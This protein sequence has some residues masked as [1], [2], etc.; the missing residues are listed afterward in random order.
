MRTCPPLLLCLL[1]LLTP[2][3]V[4]AQQS[5]STP[6]PAPGVQDPKALSVL[7]QCAQVMGTMASTAA[8][9]SSGQLT[10]SLHS[11]ESAGIV[12]EQ[13]G[14]GQMRRTVSWPEGQQVYIVNG[15]QGHATSSSTA[16]PIAP[17]QEQYFRPDYFPSLACTLD[18]TR[19]SMNAVYVDV[20]TLAGS[21]V[22]HI[23]FYAPSQSLPDGSLSLD[24]VISEFDVYLDTQSLMV[25]KTKRFIFAPDAIQNHSDW[26]TY[27]SDY[28]SVSGLMVPFHVQH[29]L[30]GQLLENIVISS[31][32]PN[33]SIPSQDFAW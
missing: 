23:R 32:Q 19:P 11:N 10:S 5:A 9:V 7:S 22:H 33:S 24:P 6:T 31:V 28:R 14:F 20:E 4:S 16:I 1:Y 30:A 25:V 17:W 2:G 29:F 8:F 26:E 27:Y 13:Q 21:Q 18:V 15:G 12:I 3:F